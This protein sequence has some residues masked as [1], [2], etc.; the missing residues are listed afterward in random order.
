VLTRAF[1]NQAFARNL[2]GLN[3]EELLAAARELLASKP[4]TK[5][6]IS[7]L[8]AQRWPGYDT[9]SIGYAVS[10]LLRTRH[11]RRRADLVN[12]AGHPIP[13]AP[14]NGGRIGTFLLDGTFEGSWRITVSKDTAVLTL[15]P[16]KALSDQESTELLNE[17]SALLDFAAAEA[18]SRTV[19][20][21]DGMR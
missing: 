21:D 1:S 18:A 2:A 13:L 8:L 4:R 11:R 3:L 6:E 20:V 14:G 12:P 16:F 10:Y 7:A 5:P 17:G 15:K 19:L 9:N